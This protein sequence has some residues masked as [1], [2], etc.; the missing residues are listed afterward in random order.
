MQEPPDAHRE[1][2]DPDALV[3]RVSCRRVELSDERHA[4]PHGAS[5]VSDWVPSEEPLEIHIQGHPWVVL[6][7]SPGHDV[8]L[9]TGFVVSERIAR[10]E[11]IEAVRQSS[12]GMDADHTVLV[13]LREGTSIDRRAHTRRGFASSSCGSCG[14]TRRAAVLD[15]AAALP[16]E[17]PTFCQPAIAKALDALSEQQP[18]FALCGG[19]HAVG[20]ANTEG[21]L[22]VVGEDIG[23]H[24]AL[25]K[26]VGWAANEGV[27]LHDKALLLSGRCSFEMAQKALAAGCGAI[28]AIGAVSALA[29]TVAQEKNMTLVGFARDGRLN[30]YTGEVG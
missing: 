16:H 21:H 9:A 27:S 8:Q 22:L 20:L 28:I 4:W 14:K 7:R 19:L 17:R 12:I 5:T 10:P 11:Q 15:L 26:V 13:T 6:M 2:S 23:R 25:D 30:V 18:G 29:I 1:N 24:N 3:Q